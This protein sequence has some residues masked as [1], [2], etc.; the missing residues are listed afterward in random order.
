[1]VCLEGIQSRIRQG[2]VKDSSRVGHELTKISPLY[3]LFK[4][5]AIKIDDSCNSI[6][7]DPSAD[8]RPRNRR[9]RA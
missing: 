8:S 9:K 7:L 6:L 4:Y 5:L 1:M 3:S 2:F